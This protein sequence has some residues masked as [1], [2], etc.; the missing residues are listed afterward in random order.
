MSFFAK[1]LGRGSAREEEVP[2]PQ[3]AIQRL[4]QTEEMLGKKREFLVK[5]IDQESEIAKANASTNKH[6]E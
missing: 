4:R 1:L 3:D 5:K 2:T 6:G